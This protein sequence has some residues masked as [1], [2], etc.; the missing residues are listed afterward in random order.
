LP[1]PDVLR[2][3][4]GMETGMGSDAIIGPE[5]GLSGVVGR[6][7]SGCMDLWYLGLIALLHGLN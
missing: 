1:L 2:V 7:C 3:Q 5:L 4:N 6:R